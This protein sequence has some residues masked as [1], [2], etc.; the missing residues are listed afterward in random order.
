MFSKDCHRV[1]DE[2]LSVREA[3]IQGFLWRLSDTGKFKIATINSKTYVKLRFFHQKVNAYAW[4]TTRLAAPP[5]LSFTT[6]SAICG[7][8]SALL[9]L[10][11]E[12]EKGPI[13]LPK[14]LPLDAILR[15]L[16]QG[17]QMSVALDKMNINKMLRMNSRTSVEKKR[18]FCDWKCGLQVSRMVDGNDSCRHNF[19]LLS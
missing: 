2:N 14:L 13:Q 6:C 8:H 17:G 19:L 5:S 16:R 12:A 9:T 10:I 15:R 11:L 7:A 18:L 3:Y 1:W 4:K